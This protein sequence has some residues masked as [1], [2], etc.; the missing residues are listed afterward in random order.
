MHMKPNKI[1]LNVSKQQQMTQKDG[2]NLLGE[3]QQLLLGNQ[4]SRPRQHSCYRKKKS[5][6]GWKLWMQSARKSEA[7]CA[8]QPLK[9]NVLRLLNKLSHKGRPMKQSARQNGIDAMLRDETASA[10]WTKIAA[11]GKN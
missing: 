11:Y 5:A 1:S 6:N 3:M 2:P 4:S 8:K 10:D 9:R 7:Q